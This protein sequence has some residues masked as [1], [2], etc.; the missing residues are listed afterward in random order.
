MSASYSSPLRRM[1]TLLTAALVMLEF[2]GIALADAAQVSL[3]LVLPAILLA[4]TLYAFA[5]SAMVKA[6]ILGQQTLFGTPTPGS[7]HDR[8][9][10]TFCVLMVMPTSMAML[11]APL[12]RL[13]QTGLG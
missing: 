13:G 4:A 11:F 2:G 8:I 9:G 5:A 10:G 12:M 3:S 1:A 7:W 6:F